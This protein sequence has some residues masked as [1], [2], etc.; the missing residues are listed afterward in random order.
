MYISSDSSYAN[1][2]V[3]VISSLITGWNYKT[4]SLSTFS[5]T[6]S[7]NQANVAKIRLTVIPLSG[8]TVNATFAGLTGVF[9]P[10]HE[11]CGANHL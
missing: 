1:D 11:G 4:V 2:Y 9:E 3:S 7:P 10:Q 5:T 6:G 8:Q